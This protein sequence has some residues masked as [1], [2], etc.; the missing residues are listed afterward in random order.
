M[1]NS[2]AN[3]TQFSPLPRFLFSDADF[4]PDL[5]HSPAERQQKYVKQLLDSWKSATQGG[6]VLNYELTNAKFRQLHGRYRISVQLNEDRCRKRRKPHPF[7]SISQPFDPDSWNFTKLE[8]KEC[9]FTFGPAT[10]A[11]NGSCLLVVNVSPLSPGHTLL[12]PAP[13][14]CLPQQ[15]NAAAL[16]R[17]LELLLLLETSNLVLIFNSLLAHASVNHLHLQALFWPS[18]SGLMAQ[19]PLVSS[20]DVHGLFLLQRPQWYLPAFVLQLLDPKMVGH[21]ASLIEQIAQHM[22]SQNV[23]HNLFMCR[24]ARLKC[25]TTTG[26]NYANGKDD[27]RKQ[28]QQE[29]EEE[30]VVDELLATIYLFPRKASNEGLDKSSA[31]ASTFVPAALEVAGLVPVYETNFFDSVTEKCSDCSIKDS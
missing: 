4:L 11:D 20:T 28:Q 10:A 8:G 22:I 12:V 23:A 1:T 19:K 3:G 16:R 29:Q 17:A 31:F 15:L 2:P 21:M 5:A 7:K 27:E 18:R 30:E 9:L 25:L 24:S 26:R 14:K 13:G 6:D